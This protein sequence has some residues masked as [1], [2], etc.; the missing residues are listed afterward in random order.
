[1]PTALEIFREVEQRKAHTASQ[2]RA[3]APGTGAYGLLADAAAISGGA[4]FSSLTRQVTLQQHQEQYR[5]NTGRV[6]AALRPILQTIAGQP[7]RVARVTRNSKPKGGQKSYEE[8]AREW[9]FKRTLPTCFKDYS[10]E[11]LE[12]LDDHPL[13]RAVQKPNPLM[14]RWML[15][16]VTV[17]SLELTGKAYWW[18]RFDKKAGWS[19]WPMPSHWVEAQHTTKK[20]YDHWL[21]RIEGTMDPIDAPAEEIMM[22]YYPDPSNPLSAIST[23]QAQARPVV[24]DEAISESQRRGYANGINPGYAVIVGRHPDVAPGVQ[25]QRPFLTKEQRGQV[26]AAIKQAYRGV[27]HHDEPMI[28]DALIEDI[29]RISNTPRE[30][31]WLQSGNY[32]RDQI[33]QGFGVN[34][35]IQGQIEGGN[36]A[37]SAA[38]GDHFVNFCINPKVSMISECLTNWLAPRFAAKNEE[39]L[40]YIEQAKAFDPDDD[41]AD[42]TILIGQVAISRNELRAKRGLPPLEDGD[43]CFVPGQG[44]FPVIREGQAGGAPPAG[45]GFR[46]ADA[47][48]FAAQADVPVAA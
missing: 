10:H 38:A 43:N 36:R 8:Q 17:A 6:H 31:D 5:H 15:M 34:P 12:V 23:L 35:L 28:L 29:R 26:M 41:R 11:Q 2:V 42:E 9:Y 44:L 33:N 30:M 24:A 39:L 3:L 16:G 40:A 1:M 37:Q 7:F 25:G 4:G 48:W 46:S 14:T 45:R 19:I 18:T 32:T 13:L 27:V 47:I 22:I 20:L 21:I